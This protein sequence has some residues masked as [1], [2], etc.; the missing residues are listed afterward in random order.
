[1]TLPIPS[2][3]YGS[4]GPKGAGKS[5]I[6]APLQEPDGGSIRLGDTDEIVWC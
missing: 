2:G 3:M 6:L 1:M 5:R 4:L